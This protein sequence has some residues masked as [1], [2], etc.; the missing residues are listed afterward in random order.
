MTIRRMDDDDDDDDDLVKGI[1]RHPSRIVI[2]P[3]M[4]SLEDCHSRMLCPLYHEFGVHVKNMVLPKGGFVQRTVFTMSSM[5]CV[6]D[7]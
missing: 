7:G 5:F 3:G 2:L 4:S 6:C 1:E